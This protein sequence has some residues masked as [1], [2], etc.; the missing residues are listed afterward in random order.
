MARV[1][2]FQFTKSWRK[3]EGIPYFPTKESSETK[4]RA[5]LQQL[6]NEIKSFINETLLDAVNTVDA[7]DVSVAS[8][9]GTM[10]LSDK[11]AE[12][13]EA[14]E[15]LDTAIE[16]ATVGTIPDNSITGTKIQHGT[17]T[18]EHLDQG[19]IEQTNLANGC[20]STTEL[21]DL[22]VT[23]AK[24]A[25]NAVNTEK[26]LDGSVT[27]AKLTSELRTT[28]TEKYAV[29]DIFI[30]TRVG[31]PATLLGYGTWEG[32]VNKFLYAAGPDNAIGSTGGE[33]E[34]T[35]TVNEMP[36]HSHMLG[37]D[38]PNGQ[39]TGGSKLKHEYNPAAIYY[40]G[41]DVIGTTGGGLAHNNLPPYYTVSMWI[42]TA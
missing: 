38:N 32:I 13:D 3:D 7:S 16:E 41:A 10:M 31:N 27:P 4:V 9:V 19:T 33:A 30:T 34:H 12:I 8:G 39:Q 17:L 42:R 11:L 28:I 1:N 29:G 26:I 35:L 24:L 36:S 14:L 21:Q 5:D 25:N 18:G 22:A 20:V 40:D 23:G 2:P 6:F 37:I 15:D